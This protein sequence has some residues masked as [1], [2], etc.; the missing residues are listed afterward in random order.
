M[1]FNFKSKMLDNRLS[2]QL[3]RLSELIVTWNIV[4]VV[5]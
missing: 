2:D 5:K 3:V 1:I 4:E